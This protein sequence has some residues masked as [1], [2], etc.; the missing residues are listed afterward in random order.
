MTRVSLLYFFSF[1]GAA[2]LT[3]AAIYADD[4]HDEATTSHTSGRTAGATT[5]GCTESNLKQDLDAH[6]VLLYGNFVITYAETR[7]IYNTSMGGRGG[8]GYNSGIPPSYD[9]PTGKNITKIGKWYHYYPEGHDIGVE[10]PDVDIEPKRR[11]DR[12]SFRTNFLFQLSHALTCGA[13]SAYTKALVKYLGKD[14]LELLAYAEDGSKKRYERVYNKAL[15]KQFNAFR[16]LS[17]LA[18]FTTD[19]AKEA[20]RFA[21]ALSEQVKALA[22]AYRGNQTPKPTSKLEKLAFELRNEIG[23]NPTLSPETLTGEMLALW[24][25]LFRTPPLSDAIVG[26]PLSTYFRDL[27]L[28][29]KSENTQPSALT[30]NPAD[31]DNYVFKDLP[32]GVLREMIDRPFA[33]ETDVEHQILANEG[34]LFFW[35]NGDVESVRKNEERLQALSDTERKSAIDWLGNKLALLGSTSVGHDPVQASTAREVLTRL[36]SRLRTVKAEDE[37]EEYFNY[38]R[39]DHFLN[40]FL[41]NPLNAEVAAE[42]AKFKK[43]AEAVTGKALPPE[44]A[45]RYLNMSP[46][47]R[48]MLKKILADSEGMK[49]G[50]R[51]NGSIDLVKL[52]DSLTHTSLVEFLQGSKAG[53]A[54]LTD[55]VR[56]GI[57][58]GGIDAADFTAQTGVEFDALLNYLQSESNRYPDKAKLAAILGADPEKKEAAIRDFLIKQLNVKKFVHNISEA[59]KKGG[60][61]TADHDRKVGDLLGDLS[62][63]FADPK[64]ETLKVEEQMAALKKLAEKHGVRT[65]EN[66]LS[67]LGMAGRTSELALKKPQG[68]SYWN[69]SEPA[70]AALTTLITQMDDLGHDLADLGS[71]DPQND[72]YEPQH[73]YQALAM[74]KFREIQLMAEMSRMGMIPKGS[75]P[76]AVVQEHLAKLRNRIYKLG[77]EKQGKQAYQFGMPTASR[78]ALMGLITP[79]HEVHTQMLEHLAAQANKAGYGDQLKLLALNPSVDDIEG[80]MAAVDPDSHDFFVRYGQ[81]DALRKEIKDELIALKGKLTPKGEMLL[82]MLAAQSL[83]QESGNTSSLLSVE[84]LYSN[85]FVE[86]MLPDATGKISKVFVPGPDLEG[87][88]PIVLA[89]LFNESAA[90]ILVK[91]TPTSEA[92][93][94]AL[95]QGKVESELSPEEKATAPYLTKSIIDHLKHM[96]ELGVKIQPELAHRKLQDPLNGP[97]ASQTRTALD[98]GLRNFF[99]GAKQKARIAAEN[100]NFAIEKLAEQLV[101]DGKRFASAVLKTMDTEIGHVEQINKTEQN[102]AKLHLLRSATT[103]PDP[104]TTLSIRGLQVA[105]ENLRASI[106]PQNIEGLGITQT[107]L[108]AEIFMR[109]QGFAQKGLGKDL[110]AYSKNPGLAD[111]GHGCMFSHDSLAREFYCQGLQKYFEEV[112]GTTDGKQLK[113]AEIQAFIA[114]LRKQGDERVTKSKKA[115]VDQYLE[116]L[117]GETGD[118]SQSDS[119]DLSK[120]LLSFVDETERNH[121][122]E[123]ERDSTQAR[124]AEEIVKKIMAADLAKIDPKERGVVELDM[125]G[126]VK[127]LLD[128]VGR[129]QGKLSAFYKMATKATPSL[130]AEVKGELTGV[131][132]AL[133]TTL[134]EGLRTS[135]TEAEKHR[136]ARAYVLYKLRGL[137]PGRDATGTGVAI[138]PSTQLDNLAGV[139]ID[140]WSSL[141]SVDRYKELQETMDEADRLGIPIDITLNPNHAPSLSG[142][143]SFESFTDALDQA[144]YAR[145]WRTS[146][147]WMPLSKTTVMKPILEEAENGAPPKFLGYEFANKEDK[148]AQLKKLRGDVKEAMHE[149]DNRIEDYG[150]FST[151][152]KGVFWNLGRW[153]GQGYVPPENKAMLEASNKYLS[154][155]SM[156]KDYGGIPVDDEGGLSGHALHAEEMQ[157]AKGVLFKERVSI[158]KVMADIGAIE[159]AGW[160]VIITVGTFGVGAYVTTLSN[161]VLLINAGR[162]VPYAGRLYAFEMAAARSVALGRPILGMNR[163]AMAARAVKTAQLGKTAFIEG[164]KGAA[165]VAPA[166]LGAQYGVANYALSSKMSQAIA[167]H[168]AGKFK[169]DDPGY[170][171]KFEG[172]NIDQNGDGIPDWDPSDRDQKLGRGRG[173]ESPSFAQGY[174]TFASN[175]RMFAGMSMAAPLRIPFVPKNL[176][177][178]ERTIGRPML[179]VAAGNMAMDAPAMLRGE[180]GLGQALYDASWAGIATAPTMGIANSTL[181]YKFLS[182]YP[183][184]ARTAHVAAITG[185]GTISHQATEAIREPIDHLLG[186]DRPK[187]TVNGDSNVESMSWLAS[188]PQSLYFN[189][190]MSGMG[191]NNY[192]AKQ[193]LNP[194]ANI[195]ELAKRFGEPSIAQAVETVL[196][197]PAQYKVKTGFEYIPASSGSSSGGTNAAKSGLPIPRIK[198]RQPGEHEP[199][200]EAIAR[201]RGLTV[202]EAAFALELLQKGYKPSD[203]ASPKQVVEVYDSKGVKLSPEPPTNS[204]LDKALAAFDMQPQRFQIEKRDAKGRVEYHAREG[205]FG[206]MADRMGIPR[207]A[208][209]K[210][211]QSE[212]SPMEDIMASVYARVAEMSPAKEK[213]QAAYQAMALRPNAFGQVNPKAARVTDPEMGPLLQTYA[214]TRFANETAI[215]SGKPPKLTTTPKEQLELDQ[216]GQTFAA[217]VLNRRAALPDGVNMEFVFNDFLGKYTTGNVKLSDA[218]WTNF[219]NTYPQPPPQSGQVDPGANRH[220]PSLN[221]K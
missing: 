179:H 31:K 89:T 163:V 24:K 136:K 189:Y 182:K 154:L 91:K 47:Y 187:V 199:L 7:R 181:A 108:K 42:Y 30:L 9:V 170:M 25:F 214:F 137:Q 172:Y 15:E 92:E 210:L 14:A 105:A 8:V 51:S 173:Y 10:D 193:L 127:M 180:K 216:L 150:A 220:S 103:S 159:E 88:I 22:E 145:G 131:K 4:K 80:L 126:K 121:L 141:N 177:T 175:F 168:K 200:L 171:K 75:D 73:V 6:P 142:G 184:L 167:D 153:S 54:V 116:K 195:E 113:P 104:T 151:T 95:I 219:R 140:G 48:G 202:D 36:K 34:N 71:L 188:L 183:R 32:H 123:Q 217:Y 45:W 205:I 110:G 166:S 115:L 133:G 18:K 94:T 119:A 38:A 122:S 169:P 149:Y 209:P 101:P 147:K 120:R 83:K 117:K 221:L 46:S 29:G 53:K 212:S 139:Y 69:P 44:S 43:E 146:D 61:P 132:Q 211:I 156:L 162:V 155:T 17:N 23:R 57:L 19:S 98:Q 129:G 112:A 49:Q 138:T 96:E 111:Y 35:R 79:D 158:D 59:I 207:W 37:K 134:G 11:S 87:R 41:H 84:E 208:N 64:T 164:L 165:F 186:L 3:S 194:K 39:S 93:A 99:T 176:L 135:A 12:P 63:H 124:T 102:V 20:P 201:R 152:A 161:A 67:Y 81:P 2:A 5:T 191:R 52:F 74:E 106:P 85:Y 206:R 218:E 21:A 28:H 66:F 185:A 26:T 109:M 114:G 198:G 62:A 82:S 90:D 27:V 174:N 13:D 190:K 50:Q 58:G 77:Q 196:A 56:K 215:Q 16:L 197:H 204:K 72:R 100:A 33:A 76:H 97:N 86:T 130:L 68:S 125:I 144:R 213:R 143:S 203:F 1:L 148:Q 178:L 70:E 107:D 128:D 65:D 55:E 40:E 78:Q 60:A 118:I 157:K 192:L 160:T